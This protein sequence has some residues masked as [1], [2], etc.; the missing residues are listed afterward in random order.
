MIDEEKSKEQLIGELAEL[1]ARFEEQS[2]KLKQAQ[3][4][5]RSLRE[6]EKRSREMADLLPQMI[7]ETDDWG[8]LIYGNR[9][10][11]E[12]LGYTPEDVKKGLNVT[13]VVIPEDR[14]I[15]IDNLV[16]TIE[17]QRVEHPRNDFTIVRKDGTTFPA[18]LW[19]SIII[20]D[21]KPAGIRGICIDITE[22]KKAEEALRKS[23]ERY[24]SVVDNASE[25]IIVAQDGMLKF[26]N[27]RALKASGYTPEELES[28]PFIELIHPDDR[29][30]VVERHAM[31]LKGEELE[32][33]YS[34]RIFTKNGNTRWMEINSVLITWNG[35]PATLNLL[36][37][38]TQRRIAQEALRQ[39]EEKLR[40]TFDS[41]K[42]DITIADMDGHI[43]DMNE[44]GLR[45][46]G[47]SRKQDI[48]GRNGLDFIAEEDRARAIED[49]TK[50]LTRK[51]G[52][53][54][55][56]Y[57]LVDKDGNR[58]D[59]EVSAS[60]LPDING[61]PAG[62]ISVVR[63]ITER[64]N[65]EKALRDSE[66][67]LR[68][69]FESMND[70][71]IIVNL[72]GRVLDVNE[73]AIKMAGFVS[74][75]ELLG[76]N[77]FDLI[78]PQDRERVMRDFA[79]RPKDKKQER[80]EYT[81]KPAHG[82]EF[83]AEI[84]ASSLVDASG[85]LIGYIAVLRDI[86]EQKKAVE[87]LRR[88]EERYRLV[89][90]NVS[91]V[92]WIMD[93]NAKYTYISPSVKRMRGYTAE[94]MMALPAHELVTTE[95]AKLIFNALSEE[96]TLE[97]SG[98]SD[99]HRVRTLEMESYNK[100]GSTIWLEVKI[101]FMRDADG[102]PIGI[103]GV[104]RDITERKRT[105]DKLKVS[106]QKY[107]ELVEQE[108]DVIFSVDE[109]GHFTSINSASLSWGFKPEEII[110]RHFSEFIPP[111]W[112]SVVPA[113]LDQ[114][115]S[116]DEITAELV[117]SDANGVGHPTEFSA[118][119][120]KEGK[121]YRG[122]R[123]I[124]RDITARKRIE[125]ALRESEQKL[126]LTFESINEA[127]ILT[128][129]EGNI[130]D[131]NEAGLRKSGYSLK[132]QL[133]GINGL[134]FFTEEA[135]PRVME[136]LAKLLKEGS[137]P[138]IASKIISRTGRVY[139]VEA[140]AVIL[141]DN[142][143]EP[144]GLIVVIRDVSDRKRME[145]AL[146]D[147]E[148]KLRL[149][150]ESIEDAIVVIDLNG[151]IVDLNEATLR[152]GGYTNKKQ[153]IGRNAFDLIAPK[154]YHMV[155]EDLRERIAGRP[156]ERMEYTIQP[157]GSEPID[158]ELT[159]ST[160]LDENGN[161]TGY[162]AVLRDITERKQ[163]E[164]QLR[165]SEQKYKE[166]VEREKDVIFSIDET[167]VI[168]SVNYAVMVWGYNPEEIIGKPYSCF[169]PARMLKKLEAEL[170]SQ[171]L[172]KGEVVAE[173][174]GLDRDGN[175][176]PI[177]F[178]AT[179]ILKEGNFA[180]VRGIV[181]DITERKRAEE[182]LKQRN[183]ELATLNKIADAVSHPV[184][185]SKVLKTALDSILETMPLVYSSVWLVDKAAPE[186]HL[187]TAR[188]D[189]SIQVTIADMKGAW[190]SGETTV[191]RYHS[192]IK[193]AKSG[194][195]RK[196]KSEQRKSIV[197][198][199]L[200]S[201]GG[202]VGV[203]GAVGDKNALSAD[204]RRLLETIGDQIAVAI[205]N[206]Q[207]V[208]RLNELSIT[209]DL[210]KLYNRRHFYE[211]LEGEINRTRR[212][213]R[214]IS[215]SMIDLDGF[216]K[217]N[218]KFG[219]ASGDAVLTDFA[220]SLKEGLRSTDTAFRYGGDEFIVILPSTNAERA[221]EV[222]ERTRKRWLKKLAEQQPGS[223][224]MLGF[225]A[226]I[227]QFP[228]N[229]ETVDGLVFLT[230]TALYYAKRGGKQRVMLI[231]DLDTSSLDALSSPTLDQ[232][233]ALAATV[234]TRDPYTYGHS[235]RVAAIAESMG[236]A[237][238]LHGD[239]LAELVAAAFLHDIGKVG[240]A[241]VIL[242]K[243]GKPEKEEWEAIKK[244]CAEGAKIIRHVKELASLAPYI[245]HH[246][247]W[248]NGT[249]Y[250]DKL[251]GQKIPL[252]ARIISVADAYDTMT[253]KRPYREAVSPA[254]ALEELERCSG[255]QFDPELIEALR[256]ISKVGLQVN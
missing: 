246:H 37:D 74:K 45:M 159:A 89:A 101:T 105:E 174:M 20:R 64:K 211:V 185:L 121:E 198:V 216:K 54:L 23:E 144:T 245:L 120:I 46:S 67:K 215:L 60:T 10:A 135:K 53:T 227:A 208:E 160:M 127:I 122:V 207:L 157:E 167:G 206:A 81:V 106:E 41:I 155:M 214:C 237:I 142:S 73:A 188:G 16:K 58:F 210:T 202:T 11:Y 39:S 8:N 242:T 164:N 95:S 19:P 114:I 171:L 132:S 109:S 79:L 25:A 14:F 152:I 33:P 238:G 232:V 179:V 110:G 77:A 168:K 138:I 252:A 99:P 118:T 26:F 9:C 83:L 84:T 94:E 137:I 117:V 166:L 240:V 17:G 139:D 151:F 75:S 205:E 102:K 78:S 181:R 108:K 112:Q 170:P 100:D 63:D 126:R 13:D 230:D 97:L 154:D 5:E 88:S 172:E 116:T 96:F 213:G 124:V 65:I 217:Y 243:P 42:D 180:G 187:S 80:L 248:Y 130:I 204:N 28:I 233:Y 113:A 229:A 62:F 1:R 2:A 107:K 49:L 186:L 119:V 56:H 140:S 18:L 91:D 228:E 12:T 136:Q 27:P 31:R 128:D 3:E 235:K 254:E 250:P 86:T 197:G 22:M 133:I 76:T 24:R 244:H 143:G 161:P 82:N 196:G 184:G 43:I 87:Q 148:E 7:F 147:S 85:N 47:Y 44:A 90:E 153:V 241:D 231:S 193:T 158:V 222:I 212:Y 203:L 15:I 38:I 156:K 4:V 178:S 195:T 234:D 92:I 69:T 224:K 104:S 145:E 52:S 40:L 219:H 165:E 149:T 201:K 129:L 249:G 125:E 220:L 199:P 6:S 182:A 253:A 146:R 175:W 209:D 30:M 192:D 134:Q 29:Q 169:A 162:I 35:K 71:L 93:M 176:R 59:A 68:L 225:S 150:F 57:T 255:T 48:I 61:N 111:E 98:N 218:D 200:K 189:K 236:R 131:I 223:E 221:K 21:N 50:Q 55:S 36:N 183:R 251:K 239:E 141:R 191:A 51:A 34:F 173:A 72:Q 190:Q 177:E 163:A 247:E 123:G 226:G 103:L 256:R 115:L 194:E 66:E 70:C 32:H